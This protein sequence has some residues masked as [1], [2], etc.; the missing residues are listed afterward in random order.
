MLRRILALLE[1]A[2][3]RPVWKRRGRGVDVL[4]YMML[5]QNTNAANAR[6]GF[7]QLTRRFATWADVLAAPIEQVQR[8]INVCGLARMRARRL[9]G[10]LA[11]IKQDRGGRISLEFLARLR[12]E[13][14]SEY[15]LKFFGIGPRTANCTLLFS[16]GMAVFP[17]D[18]QIQRLAWRTGLVRDRAGETIVERELT[19]LIPPGDRYAAHVL[20]HRHGRQVCRPRNPKCRDCV[21]LECCAFGRRRI[22]HE[23]PRKKPPRKTPKRMR[24]I[25]LSKFASAGIPKNGRGRDS[26]ARRGGRNWF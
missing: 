4:V 3:G 12:S 2:Y 18:K 24:P 9:Q 13:A 15:L 25:I 23:P 19:P 10:L 22:K 26:V 8:Q 7:R 21:L 11:A 16:F 20:M 6:S 14:A 5:A 17:V 1:R